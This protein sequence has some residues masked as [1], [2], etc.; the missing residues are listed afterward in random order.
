LPI[1][2]VRTINRKH[3]SSTGELQ[4]NDNDFRIGGTGKGVP[5]G[6]AVVRRGRE[7]KRITASESSVKS[8]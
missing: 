2:S 1:F 4:R 8:R 6:R 3:L 7:R 5:G